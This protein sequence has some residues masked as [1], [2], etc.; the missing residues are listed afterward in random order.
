[1]ILYL[2][3]EG[4]LYKILMPYFFL[5][6]SKFLHSNGFNLNYVC[7]SQLVALVW[8]QNIACVSSCVEITDKLFI[9]PHFLAG[10]AYKV[11]YFIASLV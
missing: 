10:I 5:S 2:G 7:L 1:M 6:M 9:L 3:T 8:G 11:I 4:V